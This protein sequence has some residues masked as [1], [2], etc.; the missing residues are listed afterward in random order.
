MTDDIL[1]PSCGHSLAFHKFDYGSCEAPLGGLTSK[2]MCGCGFTLHTYI[3]N[4]QAKDSTKEFERLQLKYDQLDRRHQSLMNEVLNSILILKSVQK[5]IDFLDLKLRT[6]KEL[7]EK[8]KPLS[9]LIK[10]SYRG[11][12]IKLV[13]IN[14]IILELEKEIDNV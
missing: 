1:C 3:K 10:M 2:N 12:L 9:E 5:R 8:N 14:E 6:I 11:E 4:L 13:N 7:L